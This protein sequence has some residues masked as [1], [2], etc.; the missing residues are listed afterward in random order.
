MRRMT[1]ILLALLITALPLV[2]KK[3][4]Q[5]TCSGST[6]VLPIAQAA[7]E[8]FMAKNPDVNVSIRGGGSGVGIAALL[9]GSTDI[10]SSSRP[11]KAKEVTQAKRKGINPTAYFVA[12]D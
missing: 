7:A 4:N 11:M 5:L 2:A 3:A 6:T 1:F 9:A 8:A 12:N 10:A